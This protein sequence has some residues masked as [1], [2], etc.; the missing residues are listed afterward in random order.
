[1]AD[2]RM[3]SAPAERLV[4]AVETTIGSGVFEWDDRLRV[5]EVRQRSDQAISSAR[6]SVRVDDTFDAT[7]ALRRYHRDC[8][9]VVS[10]DATRPEDREYLF[11]GYMPFHATQWDGRVG[12]EEERYTL[13]GEH[14][15]A[16]LSR[17]PE[18]WIYGRRVRSGAIEDGLSTAP[19]AFADKSVLMT[20]L[21]CVFNPDGVGNCASLPLAV[22]AGGGEGEATQAVHVFDDD[23]RP[24][25]AWTYARVLRYLVWLYMGMDRVI[26]GSEVFAATD[27][28]VEASGTSVDPLT[29]A[30]R[31]EPVSLSCE[32]VNLVEALWLV[33]QAA[34]I[35]LSC[36]TRNEE[37]RPRTVLKVWAPGSGAARCLYLARGGRYPDGVRYYDASSRSARQVLA[38]N[39]THRGEASWDHA[40]VINKPIVVGDVRRYEMTVELVPGWI[41]RNH[42]DNVLSTYRAAARAMAMTPSQVDMAGE[43]A[44][45]ELWFR[46]YHRRGSDFKYHGDVSR[47]WVLN[48]DGGFP[49]A[50]Y[51]RNFPW[52]DYQAFD[53]SSVAGSSVLAPGGW[54]RRRRRLWPCVSRSNE[55][56]EPGVWVEI[57]FDLGTTWHQQGSGVRILT[58]RV[59]IYFDCE[60]PTDI[61][62][63]GVAPEDDNMWFSILEQMFRVRVTGVIESDNRLVAEGP[64]GQI[65]TG[66]V[67]TNATMIR[68]PHAYQYIS[69][70]E[71]TNV[72]STLGASPAT[73]DDREALQGLADYLATVNQDRQVRVLPAIPWVE[74]GYAMGDQITE[75]RGRHLRFPTR[76]PDRTHWPAVIER[77]F[78]LRDG[79]YETELTLGTTQ[80][81]GEA[82]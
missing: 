12:Q 70:S 29:E 53:F 69:R 33:A 46:M 61:T 68:R 73:R 8:R 9:F 49:G 64:S 40:K 36:T 62:P 63:P 52:H 27:D 7:E 39:N 75:I 37:G 4:A 67:L 78:V 11:E 56:Q 10:T 23:A 32:A 6:V 59:G 71:T 41:P 54:M 74:T 65:A 17:A 45:S 13:S 80:V 51:N 2:M 43:D 50:L 1:M 72:L 66:S 25:E 35:H 47:L 57:S 3:R 28:L 55:G 48:E 18:A 30:L 79:R 24:A 76:S 81:S 19:T 20:A 5:E 14:V 77:R 21:P 38:E 31:R 16:R 26:D 58:D 15:L 22:P 82:V 60:N 34:G 42:L 44:A